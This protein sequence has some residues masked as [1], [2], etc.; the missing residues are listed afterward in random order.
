MH[1]ARRLILPVND[2]TLIPVVRRQPMPVGPAPE[3]AGIDDFAFRLTHHGDIVETG[4]DGR[5][6]EHTA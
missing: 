6:F 3:T 5:R 1:F 2:D 4:N